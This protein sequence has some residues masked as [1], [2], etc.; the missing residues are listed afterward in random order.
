MKAMWIFLKDDQEI[1]KKNFAVYEW[2]MYFY[3]TVQMQWLK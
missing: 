3:Y 2:R 1:K